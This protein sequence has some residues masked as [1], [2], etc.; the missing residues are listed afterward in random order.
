MIMKPS[1]QTDEYNYVSPYYCKFCGEEEHANYCGNKRMVDNQ[2]CF[3][4][5]YWDE[6]TA[7]ANESIRVKGTHYMLGP[8]GDKPHQFNG[9]G[10]RKFVIKMKDGKLVETCDL[11][12]QG[13]IPARFQSQLPDNAE[14]VEWPAPIGHG[15]GFLG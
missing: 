2:L 7:K 3:D 6:L 12:Y 4:C 8:N 15:Q 10:G 14:F 11:W 1:L 9:F 5:N 13:R